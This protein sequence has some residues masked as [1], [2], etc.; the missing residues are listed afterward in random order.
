[1]I[2]GRGMPFPE[3]PVRAA[4]TAMA[5][6]RA[7]VDPTDDYRPVSRDSTVFPASTGP[8]S[9]LAFR[10]LGGALGPTLQAATRTVL[11]ELDYN[12]R[13]TSPGRELARDLPLD[14]V[15]TV[16]AIPAQCDLARGLY[17]RMRRS[18]PL[19][20]SQRM[21]LARS[22]VMTSAYLGL[23]DRLLIA[24][25]PVGAATA[26][27]DARLDEGFSP[28]VAQVAVDQLRWSGS[29]DYATSRLGP[30]TVVLD[31]LGPGDRVRFSNLPLEQSLDAL[32]PA[33]AAVSLN[34][35][36]SAWA[37]SLDLLEH[38]DG[39]RTL[40]V[41][42]LP[43]RVIHRHYQLLVKKYLQGKPAAPA[44][45]TLEAPSAYE[46][47]YARL[48]DFFA[49]N[50]S[51]LGQVDAVAV[52]YARCFRETWTGVPRQK[53][54]DSGSSW[55]ADVYTL[56]DGKRLA[57]LA[58]QDNFQGEVLGESLKRLVQDHPSIR[59]IFLAGSGGSLHVR[60]PYSIVFPDR[61]GDTPNA[62]STRT[63][64]LA[65][66]S[67][68][69]PLAE[70]PE[71]LSD[72]ARRGVTTLDMEFGHAATALRGLPVTLGV[73]VL[74]TDF[75]IERS[76]GPG[77][78]L[79]RQDS[80][81]KYANVHRYTRAV[82]DAL[83]CGR[84]ALEHPLEQHLGRSLGE[85]STRNL[86]REIELVGEMGQA[87]RGLFERLKTL[88]P[89][90]SFRMTEARLRRVLEDGAL[91]ST[92]QVARLLDRPVDPYTP[93][94][95][96]QM[97]GAYEHTFGAL[98]FGHGDERYGSIEVRLRPEVWKARSWATFASG[99]KALSQVSPEK[100][101]Y[102]RV[103]PDLLAPARERF[104][105]WVV[106][107]KDYNAVVAA[108]IV[109]S[110]SDLSP[111]LRR[112]LLAAP[113][114]QLPSLLDRHRLWYLEGKIQ[115]SLNLEDIEKLIVPPDFPEPLNEL[116]RQRGIV[117]EAR[118]DRSS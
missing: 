42:E 95:E 53:V 18:R 38:D 62:L 107:P 60:D 28:E 59:Q 109:G 86:E 23:D 49:R 80:G 35:P 92:G 17:D 115:G 68:L 4:A 113:P 83:T 67:V 73:G 56:A 65:H 97:F 48:N 33:R 16:S 51:H 101:E 94:V 40:V 103:D 22:L 90:Y 66:E 29:H 41:G 112:E 1:M 10:L 24:P 11:D 91:L 47:S 54:L 44:V 78:N 96:D 12:L 74:A 79:T 71:A 5:P 98:G 118:S 58:S 31:D 46:G 111:E 84:P 2:V 55:K 93:G 81:R 7:P 69:S 6:E 45:S 14:Q 8:A 77:A 114:D 99:W 76:V 15:E 50:A 72:A 9:D 25:R 3:L 70:T 82:Y 20:S 85:L 102:D 26:P 106:T 100:L 117:V 39:T 30:L 88:A 104:S 36:V 13:R 89:H 32:P 34:L 105:R 75:P 61:I 110:L 63:T 27:S 52:G 116:C 21:L 64:N 87:E 37:R 108:G 19:S 57:V 43:G